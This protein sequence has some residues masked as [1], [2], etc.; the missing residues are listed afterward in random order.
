MIGCI[1]QARMG[2]SRFPGK[3]M[4]KIDD[5]YPVIYYVIEQLK[6]C[7]FLDE[8]VV[9]TTV[10]KEDNVIENYIR[11]KDIQCF[12]GSALDVLD[13]YYQCAKHFSFSVFSLCLL[14]VK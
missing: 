8:I 10:L 3:V 1:V 7:N 5:K 6:H 12:R 11:K 13:R 9:A 2:S 14:K 4:M